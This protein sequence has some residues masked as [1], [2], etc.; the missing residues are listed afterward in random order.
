MCFILQEI[1]QNYSNKNGLLFCFVRKEKGNSAAWNWKRKWNRAGNKFESKIH[2]R[3]NRP[4]SF[5]DISTSG[6]VS[7]RCILHWWSRLFPLIPG[8]YHM[9]IPSTRTYIDT[10]YCY[11]NALFSFTRALPTLSFEFTEFK[12]RFH[13]DPSAEWREK[14]EKSGK[15]NNAYF[16]PGAYVN[17]IYWYVT[18]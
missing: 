3:K 1:P 13:F 10:L 7:P 14:Q 9:N 17:W 16:S 2:M 4:L 12:E 6:I 8:K 5:G 11:F 15:K 18:E